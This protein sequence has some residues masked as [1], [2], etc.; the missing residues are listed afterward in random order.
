MPLGENVIQTSEKFQNF[1]SKLTTDFDVLGKKFNDLK[2][3]C[4]EMKVR[5]LSSDYYKNSPLRFILP[6]LAL[7]ACFTFCYLAGTTAILSSVLSQTVLIGAASASV[8]TL[9]QTTKDPFQPLFED[10]RNI[11]EK[12]EYLEK[13]C[14]DLKIMHEGLEGEEDCRDMLLFYIAKAKKVCEKLLVATK[15]VFNQ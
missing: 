4:E 11:E 6:S 13:K 10:L 12:S 15:P 2:A 9:T 7:V 3:N 14:E 8:I 5:I 1:F